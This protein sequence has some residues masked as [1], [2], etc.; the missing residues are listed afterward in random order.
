MVDVEACKYLQELTPS[1]PPPIC[2][3]YFLFNLGWGG[4]RKYSNGSTKCLRH[5]PRTV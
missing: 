3:G 5:N 2:L 4:K 1:S